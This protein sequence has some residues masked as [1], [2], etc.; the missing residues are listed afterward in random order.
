MQRLLTKQ[1][2]SFSEPKPHIIIFPYGIFM[3]SDACPICSKPSAMPYAPF[4][5]GRCKQVDLGR[6]LTGS[7]AI[8]ADDDLEAEMDAESGEE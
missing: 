2:T 7:Y 3:P 6:W 5:S 4:C 8:P 1:K